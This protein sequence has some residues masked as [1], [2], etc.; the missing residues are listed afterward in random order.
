MSA[1]LLRTGESLSAERST[2]PV[3]L[4]AK[5][6]RAV[7]LDVSEPA[8]PGFV[9]VTAAIATGG[10]TLNGNTNVTTNS[11]GVATFSNLS[12]TG[13]AG[14]RTLIFSSPPLLSV[15]SNSISIT[16]GAAAQRS[17]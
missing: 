2:G 13:A 1:D 5:G 11:N 15:T 6:S 16:G 14:S 12:I 8:K 3:A 17:R 7:L 10:G 9:L 4:D